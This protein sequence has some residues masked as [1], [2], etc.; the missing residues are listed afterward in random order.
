M[1]LL[2]KARCKQSYCH[3]RGDCENCA[4][5]VD[6]PHVLTDSITSVPV[7]HRESLAT[8]C[9]S[10][11]DRQPLKTYRTL[12]VYM[13]GHS[14]TDTEHPACAHLAPITAMLLPWPLFGPDVA[15]PLSSPTVKPFWDAENTESRSLVNL[16]SA[17]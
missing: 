8:P 10:T 3:G 6:V 2:N 4:S 9:P 14:L 12:C 13:T 11:Y 16:R 5:C 7:G 17:Q 1:V 15:S